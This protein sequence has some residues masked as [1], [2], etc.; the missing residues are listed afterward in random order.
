LWDRLINYQLAVQFSIAKGKNIELAEIGVS[1]Y[2]ANW[3]RI[4]KLPHLL[5][6][7]TLRRYLDSVMEQAIEISSLYISSDF[8]SKIE[9]LLIK[10]SEI[11]NRHTYE[12]YVC[13]Q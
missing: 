3:K 12:F 2:E 7:A 11:C 8:D 1:Q 10:Q 4:K 5:G 13:N 9:R 6:D